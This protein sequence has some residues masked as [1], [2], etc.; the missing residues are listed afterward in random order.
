MIGDNSCASWIFTVALSYREGLETADKRLQGG[1]DT[2]AVQSATEEDRGFAIQ[3]FKS[4]S[5]RI[6]KGFPHIF[7]GFFLIGNG[8][9]GVDDFPA[10]GILFETFLSGEV[11]TGW[12]EGNLVAVRCDRL[13]LRGEDRLSTYPAVIKRLQP[14][15]V[16]GDYRLFAIVHGQR[17]RA[18]QSLEKAFAELPVKPH[19]LLRPVRSWR[20]QKKTVDD[21]RAFWG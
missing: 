9:A 5:Y 11:M 18:F 4:L 2:A 3:N 17:E 12:E 15:W 20:R 14:Y 8:L 19:D 13:Q 10:S 1:R 16:S 21:G 6:L 7:D